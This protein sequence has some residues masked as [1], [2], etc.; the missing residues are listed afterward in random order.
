MTRTNAT[1][2]YTLP[3]DSPIGPLVLESDGTALTGI[4]LPGETNGPIGPGH[5]A[6]PVL[7]DTLTPWK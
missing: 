2:S 4:W 7:K 3:M 6:P 1:P 5:D